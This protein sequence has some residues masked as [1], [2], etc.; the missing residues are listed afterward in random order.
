MNWATDGV[1]DAVREALRTSPE[2]QQLQNDLE[3][4]KRATADTR[5]YVLLQAGAVTEINW[6]VRARPG[7]APGPGL[8]A[9]SRGAAVITPAAGHR[10]T[11]INAVNVAIVSPNWLPQVL[12]CT[13]FDKSGIELPLVDISLRYSGLSRL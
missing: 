10:P 5:L 13:V 9:G 3:V 12:N 2:V 8:G 6:V 1:R 4:A 7:Q 11:K